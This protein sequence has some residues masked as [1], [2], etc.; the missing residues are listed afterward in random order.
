MTLGRLDHRT[1]ISRESAIM[2]KRRTQWVTGSA[3]VTMMIVLFSAGSAPAAIFAD[4]DRWSWTGT[5]GG[6]LTQGDP[7]TLLWSILPDGTNTAGGG[8][9]SSDLV[10]TFD[11]L[12]GDGGGGS[13]LTQRPWFSLFEDSFNRYDELSGL[14][15]VHTTDDGVAMSSTANGGS[16]VRGDIRVGGRSIDGFS[17]TLAFAF[18]PEFGEIVLDTDDGASTFSFEK[19]ARNIIMHETGH[20]IG[21]QHVVSNDAEFLLEPSLN[22]GIDGPQF[23]DLLAIQRLYGDFH[24]KSNNGQGNNIVGNATD[25]GDLNIPL[26]PPLQPQITLGADADSTDI[27]PS[28][29]DFVSID[30]RLD[31][32]YYSFTLTEPGQVN[33]TLTPMGPTY[34]SAPESNPNNVTTI[35]ASSRNDL[36]LG[37]RGADGELLARSF[38]GGLGQAETLSWVFDEAGTYHVQV[39][40]QF[41][42]TIQFYQLDLSAT[43]PTMTNPTPDDT[44]PVDHYL[45]ESDGDDAAGGDADATVGA[46]VAFA[47]G[48]FGQAAVFG[49]AGADADD[50]LTVS[51][52]SAFDPSFG[53]FSIAFRIKHAVTGTVDGILDANGGTGYQMLVG[54]ENRIRLRLDDANGNSLNL[55]SVAQLSGDMFD[56]VAITVDRFSH[57]AIFYINGVAEIPLDIA[58]LDGAFTPNQ[59]LWIGAINLGSNLGLSGTLDDLRF[60]DRLLTP[61]QVSNLATVVIPT[62]AA[63]PAGL[64]LLGMTMPRRRRSVQHPVRL[65]VHR[66][67]LIQRGVG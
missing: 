51:Q 30:S 57:E 32:D 38:S 9:G 61:N 14:T 1:V 60:Y 25:L 17:G 42:S 19:A 12:Y 18:F 7:T 53:D 41:K 28:E 13:D 65:R 48:V 15:M 49:A 8:G 24:E 20:A 64:I 27:D 33:M 26:L 23:D 54:I 3:C 56:H 35:D 43:T 31:K 11:S 5:D 6:G 16:G 34:N 2:M 22:L 62:P 47:P 66:V 4:A 45:F 39:T 58:V 46:D 29:T 63:L 10:A 67:L 59:D 37:I 44:P 36:H 50:V 40:G 21:I 52:T 55:D